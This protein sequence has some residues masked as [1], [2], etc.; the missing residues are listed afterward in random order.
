MKIL[1]L[2]QIEIAFRQVGSCQNKVNAPRDIRPEANHA[3]KY[4]KTHLRCC[5]TLFFSPPHLLNKA[6]IDLRPFFFFDIYIKKINT[7]V[8]QA[9]KYPSQGQL[10]PLFAPHCDS[11][12]TSQIPQSRISTLLLLYHL[13]P[14]VTVLLHESFFFCALPTPAIQPQVC[15]TTSSSPVLCTLLRH[16][17]ALQHQASFYATLSPFA[18]H[19][20]PSSTS[21][22][23]P[24]RAFTLRG[25]I[26]YSSQHSFIAIRL[27]T[28]PPHV[29]FTKSSANLPRWP[30][31]NL[32][33]ASPLSKTW[34]V[35]L[36]LPWNSMA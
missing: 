18:T 32:Q 13:L 16:T 1:N 21:I 8:T 22:Y 11:V 20:L 14:C 35:T 29:S 23:W 30:R 6:T 12:A 4:I 10:T 17:S 33:T 19:P 9:F 25:S 5:S 7:I 31:R 28:L 24:S 2:F 15:T 26:T 27:F 3:K 34:T 36:R